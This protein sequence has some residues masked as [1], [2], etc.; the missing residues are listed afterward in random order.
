MAPGRLFYIALDVT[1]EYCY[2]IV[3][4]LQEVVD[5]ADELLRE[6]KMAHKVV[7]EVHPEQ[8]FWG[9]NERHP[10]NRPSLD[11]SSRIRANQ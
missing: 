3:G 4:S 11:L 10:M 8:C 1:G 6:S 2:G 9:L 5:K 7:Q